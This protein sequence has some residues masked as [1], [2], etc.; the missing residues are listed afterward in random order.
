MKCNFRLIGVVGGSGSGK[1]WLAASLGKRLGEQAGHLCL[2]DFYR[3]LGH[4]PEEQRGL[5]NFDDPA[6]I[7]WEAL[8]E[9]IECLERGESAQV[10]VYDF[11]THTRLAAWRHFG[12]TPVLVMEGLWLLHPEWLRE[13]YALSIFVDCPEA[14]RLQRRIERDVRE[15]GRTAESVREQFRTHVKPMHDQFVEPQTQW[16]MRR[17]RSPLT[18]AE[19]DELAVLCKKF[20]A[21][22]G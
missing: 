6:A 22:L 13:K 21:G 20:D 15:R 19:Q 17:V 14:E 12:F 2:D 18:E 10:P 16:A 8:R 11:V 5:V 9:V 3:D 7:D 4:L 1:S